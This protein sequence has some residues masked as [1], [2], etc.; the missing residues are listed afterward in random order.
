[1][2]RQHSRKEVD[3]RIQNGCRYQE[4]EMQWQLSSS[5]YEMRH[6][7]S[8]AIRMIYWGVAHISATAGVVKFTLDAAP[9]CPSTFELF[10]EYQTSPSILLVVNKANTYPFCPLGDTVLQSWTAWLPSSRGDNGSTGSAGFRVDI[11][12]HY[13]WLVKVTK[14]APLNSADSRLLL[15]FDL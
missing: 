8:Q 6:Q 3:L 2:R 10:I 14:F 13:W 7:L 5:S 12:L 11:F 1:M 15:V 4:G 9:M